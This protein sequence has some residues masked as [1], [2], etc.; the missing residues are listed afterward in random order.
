MFKEHIQFQDSGSLGLYTIALL[1]Q[2]KL[3]KKMAATALYVCSYHL[4]EAMASGSF[5]RLG[6]CSHEEILKL[7]QCQGVNK[8]IFVY[9][10]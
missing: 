8:I 10:A 6:N 5:P 4:G 3:E 7:L 2:Y 9:K 1:M